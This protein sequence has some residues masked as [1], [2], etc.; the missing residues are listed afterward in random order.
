MDLIT[1]DWETF[2]DNKFTLTRLT[3]EEYIRS[4]DFEAIGVGVKL[5]D[6]ETDWLSGSH[7]E[8]KKYLQKKYN[9]KRSG[10]KKAEDTTESD[11][12]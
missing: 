5:N 10:G 12:E 3:T 2:Y 9:W 7:K 4:P 8:L 1:L 11:S 6:G